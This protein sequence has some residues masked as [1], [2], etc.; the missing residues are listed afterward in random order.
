MKKAVIMLLLLIC[1]LPAWAAAE[2]IEQ[3]LSPDISGAPWCEGIVFDMVMEE[4]E[5]F[6][7]PIPCYQTEYAE[8][9]VK[10]IRALMEQYGLPKPDGETWYN[11]KDEINKRNYVFAEMN[12]GRYQLY[13]YPWGM[14]ME[15]AGHPQEEKL[16]AAMEVCRRFLSESGI[17]GIEEPYY[18]VQRI[19]EHRQSNSFG[20]N[21]ADAYQAAIDEK[22]GVSGDRFTG[23]G[24]RYTLDGLPVAVLALYD[25]TDADR[26]D[27]YFDSWGAMTIRDDGVITHFELRNYRAIAKELEPYDGLVC[28]WEEAVQ[29]MLDKMIHHTQAERGGAEAT[30]WLEDHERLRIVHVEPNLAVAPGGTTFPVW[31]VV[32]EEQYRLE[33][34]KIYYNSG[35]QYVDAR[36]GKP[37]EAGEDMMPAW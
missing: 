37:A 18:V 6:P 30:H 19:H 10:Q 15:I 5:A 34:G 12:N 36:T 24:F 3:V 9:N 22:Q 11:G 23:I 29:T 14:R 13:S 32:Y 8:V 4:P 28:S 17:G 2:Q 35:V 31:A 27:G 26:R 16:R 25:P 7:S 20:R 21:E 33:N 1:F